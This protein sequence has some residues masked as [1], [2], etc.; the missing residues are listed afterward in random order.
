[1]GASL[2]FVELVDDTIGVIPAYPLGED[3]LV[4]EVEIDKALPQ[5]VPSALPL[6]VLLRILVQHA[7]HLLVEG[8]ELLANVADLLLYAV[9]LLL[10]FWLALIVAVCGVVEGRV[11]SPAGAFLALFEDAAELW[12]A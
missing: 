10:L 11:F 7:F 4:G 5:S 6:Q 2:G 9:E 3:G 12:G 8:L 1:M